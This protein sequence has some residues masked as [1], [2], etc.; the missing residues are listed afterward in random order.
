MLLVSRWA[1][2]PLRRLWWILATVIGS[3]VLQVG[4]LGIDLSATPSTH[5]VLTMKEFQRRPFSMT[6]PVVPTSIVAAP[7]KSRPHGVETQLPAQLLR[8]LDSHGFPGADIGSDIGPARVYTVP[9]RQAIF[10]AFGSVI[11]Q[12]QHTPNPPICSDP[13]RPCLPSQPRVP[14]GWQKFIRLMSRH[15]RI[16]RAVRGTLGGLPS[17]PKTVPN[18]SAWTV[19]AYHHAPTPNF[20]R[21]HLP[22]FRGVFIVIHQNM[23]WILLSGLPKDI[24]APHARVPTQLI[25]APRK[26]KAIPIS[27]ISSALSRHF[28]QR[29]TQTFPIRVNVNI[30]LYDGSSTRMLA[31]LWNQYHRLNTYQLGYNGG[32]RYGVWRGMHWAYL[33]FALGATPTPHAGIWIFVTPSGWAGIVANDS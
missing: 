27:Q 16:V 15:S 21:V 10:W 1:K 14:V 20:K 7:P 25:P 8:A 12:A 4:L 3:L 2:V 32:D 13:H 23:V 26:A 9:N 18:A 29:L 17:L 6:L 30:R 19:V 11:L 28:P 33:E 24:V 22:Y 5:S 31:W